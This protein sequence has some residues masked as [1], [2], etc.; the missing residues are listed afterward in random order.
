MQV[1]QQYGRDILPESH[2]D[3]KLVRR[4]ADRVIAAVKKADRDVNGYTD[5][6]RDYEWEVFVVRSKTPNA[7]VVPGGKI[8]VFT[9]ANGNVLVLI[10]PAD[11]SFWLTVFQPP[12]LITRGAAPLTMAHAVLMDMPCLLTRDV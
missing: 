9:G 4:I 6:M 12:R 7:F 8:V 10:V 1:K 11:I 2:P 3:S 5:H